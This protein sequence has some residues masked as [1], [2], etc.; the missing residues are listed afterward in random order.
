MTFS[1]K[2]SVENYKIQYRL[3]SSEVWRDGT[4]IKGLLPDT[5]YTIHFRAKN[6]A[7][8]GASAT[9]SVRTMRAPV[10]EKEVKIDLD[11]EA[12][13]L[14][15]TSTTDAPLEYRLLT[16]SGDPVTEEWASLGA[17]ADLEKDT[18]YLLQVRVAATESGMA[19][20]ITEIKIDTHEVKEP[21]SL[22][23]ALSDGFLLV[24]GGMLFLVLLI[25]VIGFARSAKRAKKEEL[26]G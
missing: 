26:G 3:D 17:F 11:R 15:V 4:E 9:L 5:Q 16:E 13:T 1:L 7:T 10:K 14:N 18:T 12:G 2:N 20:E 6:D 23:K 25:V 8:S 19:S 22:K 21:F 24:V